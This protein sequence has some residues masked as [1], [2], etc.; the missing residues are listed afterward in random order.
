VLWPIPQPM[1]DANTQGVINQNFGY[2]GYEKN[3]APLEA[4]AAEEQ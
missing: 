4:I 2:A 3:V 1:I